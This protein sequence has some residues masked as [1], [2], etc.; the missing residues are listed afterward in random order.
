MKKWQQVLMACALFAGI[1]TTVLSASNAGAINVFNN[2][3]GNGSTR[4]CQAAG[5]DDA[6][7]MVEIIINTMLFVLGMVAVIMIVVG[8]IRY[9]TSNGDAGRI[10]AAK[11]TIMYSVAGLVVAILSFAIVNF[12]VRQF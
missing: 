9:V 4:V 7:S 5:T 1:G 8:G 6:T 3:S 2:C 12:V 10:K 11:E